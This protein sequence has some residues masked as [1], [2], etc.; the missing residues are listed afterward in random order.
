MVMYYPVF[1][2]YNRSHEDRFQSPQSCSD[3]VDAVTA[4]VH[5]LRTS[6]GKAMYVNA[7]RRLRP[8]L[9]SANILIGHFD[10][11]SFFILAES[12]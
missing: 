11:L 4:V 1:F 10:A 6:E 7:S 12:A 3:V 2:E 8:Y 5:R 9:A